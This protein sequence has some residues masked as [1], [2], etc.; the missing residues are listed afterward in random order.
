MLSL[1]LE[2]CF[3]FVCV[4]DQTQMCRSSISPLGLFQEI[5]CNIYDVNYPPYLQGVEIFEKPQKGGIKIFVSNLWILWQKCSLLSKSFIQNVYCFRIKSQSGVAYKSVIYKKAFNIDFYS[6]KNE[7]ITVPHEF[8]FVFTRY[9]IGAILLEKS[10]QK[11]GVW[12]KYKKG[13]RHVR[14][15]PIEGRFKP[16]AY[17]DIERLKGGI[18]EPWD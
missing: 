13:D 5:A 17:Y 7:E 8:I 10:C 14:G 4:V 11:H 12:K 18:L 6:S 16:S 2:F 15:L 3:L 1:L 9:F